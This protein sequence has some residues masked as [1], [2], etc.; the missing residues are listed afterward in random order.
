V[1]SP[2]GGGVEAQLDKMKAMT[3]GISSRLTIPFID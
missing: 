2:A 3:S 1:S